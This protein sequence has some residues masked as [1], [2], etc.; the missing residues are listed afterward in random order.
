[1]LGCEHAWI[2]AGAML[3]AMNNHGAIGVTDGQI[4]EA[5]N[6]TR[7]QAIGAYCGLPKGSGN[8]Y[9]YASGIEDYWSPG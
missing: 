9:N 1:M 8:C 3:V 4:V 2:A 6:R 5:L 7:R